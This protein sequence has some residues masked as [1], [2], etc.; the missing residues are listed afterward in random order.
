MFFARVQIFDELKRSSQVIDSLYLLYYCDSKMR[1][2]NLRK[3][4]SIYDR[5]MVLYIWW[6]EPSPCIG[7]SE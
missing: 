6:C 4:Y 3:P 2:E 1:P 5:C 7:V